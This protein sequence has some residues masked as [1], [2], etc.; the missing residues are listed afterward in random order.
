MDFQTI[1][2][3]GTQLGALLEGWDEISELNYWA[4][5]AGFQKLDNNYRILEVK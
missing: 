4:R 3:T 1:A 2:E 5:R